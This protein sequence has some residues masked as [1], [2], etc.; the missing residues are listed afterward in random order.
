MTR[1]LRNEYIPAGKEKADRESKIWTDQHPRRRNRYR[2][3][4]TLSLV[5][6]KKMWHALLTSITMHYFHNLKERG[7]SIAPASQVRSS[8]IL[9]LLIV[10]NLKRTALGYTQVAYTKFR[11]NLSASPSVKTGDTAWRLQTPTIL[12]FTKENE[13][14]NR[15]WK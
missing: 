5:S 2:I 4:Y 9:S 11:R 6:I 12:V 8:A 14:N 1:V 7:A 3:V 13:P 15:F 10:W